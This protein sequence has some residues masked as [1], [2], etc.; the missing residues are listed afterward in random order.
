MGKMHH[1]GRSNK[2]MRFDIVISQYSKREQICERQQRAS[3]I[4]GRFLYLKWQSN[5]A[6]EIYL[7]CF[8]CID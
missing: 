2:S 8:L 5:R 4:G 7:T 6:T 1:G 3:L